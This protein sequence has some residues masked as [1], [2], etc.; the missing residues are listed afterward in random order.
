MRCVILARNALTWIT[1]ANFSLECERSRKGRQM[2]CKWCDPRRYHYDEKF[3]ARKRQ[4]DVRAA[5][6]IAHV[7]VF[8]ANSLQC[9]SCCLS[10]ILDVFLEGV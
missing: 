3:A 9:G 4:F 1:I 10:G 8:L 5:V 7:L 2:S 6:S